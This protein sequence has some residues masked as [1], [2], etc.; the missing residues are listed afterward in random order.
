MQIPRETIYAALYALL[1]NVSDWNFVARRFH[2]ISELSEGQFPAMLMVQKKELAEAGGRGIPVKWT[3]QLD[4]I[5]YVDTT[6][7]PA[8]VPSQ[9]TNQILDD[10]EAVIQPNVSNMLSLPQT[11]G[12]LVSQC[13][14]RGEIITDEGILGSHGFIMVPIEVVVQS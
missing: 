12:G 5:V 10:L 11:L 1:I 14:I 4:V 3:L 7:S 8:R 13:R 6:N 2:A 9:V